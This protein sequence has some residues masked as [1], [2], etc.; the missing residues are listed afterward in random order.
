MTTSFPMEFFMPD[1][2]PLTPRLRTFSPTIATLD[3]PSLVPGV[4]A[5]LSPDAAES[6]GP[7]E[8]TALSF[9]DALESCLDAD[10]SN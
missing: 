3:A 8:E 2:G 9:E 4:I 10:P 5:N 6:F 1:H 7:F